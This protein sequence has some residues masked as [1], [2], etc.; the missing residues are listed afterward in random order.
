MRYQTIN[1]QFEN[2]EMWNTY[3][4]TELARA[5]GIP[6]GQRPG[7]GLATTLVAT[8]NNILFFPPS[9]TFLKDGVL[10]LKTYLAKV[11]RSAQNPTG[12]P[13]SRPHGHF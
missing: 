6:V 11:D 4:A 3:T 2:T 5:V 9:S 8:I 1:F 12:T 10:G 7:G 13:L